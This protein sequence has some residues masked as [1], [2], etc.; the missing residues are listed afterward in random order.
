[1]ELRWLSGNEILEWVNPICKSRGWVEL[2]VNDTQPTCRVLGAFDGERLIGWL[3]FQL[4]PLLGPFYV[5]PDQRD[6]LV[7]AALSDEMH[8][9]IHAVGARGVL[10]L[11]ENVASERLARKHGMIKVEDKVYLWGGM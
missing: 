9:F 11:C 3:A 7:S 1:M 6:G 8:Q 10:T 2:N 4:F 5:E